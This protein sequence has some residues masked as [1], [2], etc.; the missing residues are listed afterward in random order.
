MS[1]DIKNMRLNMRLDSV[2]Y[3]H[4]TELANENK[5]TLSAVVES[6]IDMYLTKDINTESLIFASLENIRRDIGFV[7]KKIE[8]FFNFFHFALA[9]ILVGVPDLKNLDDKE[10]NAISK[11]ALARRDAMIEGFKKQLA[12]NPSMFERL[13]ADYIEQENEK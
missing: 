8:T 1:T 9:T 10:A 11:N 7:D 13:L 3:K 4:I 2:K 5:R 12:S 6:A